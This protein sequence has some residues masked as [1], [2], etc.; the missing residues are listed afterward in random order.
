MRRRSLRVLWKGEKLWNFPWKQR[1][2]GGCFSILCGKYIGIHSWSRKFLAAYVYWRMKVPKAAKLRQVRF[3][4]DW[5]L[6][7]HAGSG[8][9]SLPDRNLPHEIG[10]EKNGPLY[11][12]FQKSPNHPFYWV[13][14]YKPSVWGT[15]IFGNT[16]ILQDG[17]NKPVINGVTWPLSMAFSRGICGYNP[18]YRSDF[19]PSL[20]DFW[21]HLVG[22][23]ADTSKCF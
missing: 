2:L 23:P 15:P 12:C 6:T 21:A 13:F 3:A 10:R 8:A 19:S 18:T 7:A 1:W 17:H 20:I 9:F 4:M 11:G 22:V 5:K 16:H 14:H